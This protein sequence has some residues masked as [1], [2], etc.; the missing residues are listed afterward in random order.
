VRS[1]II[2]VDPPVWQDNATISFTV[3]DGRLIRRVIGQLFFTAT[4]ATNANATIARGG[5][6]A[7][8]KEIRVTTL[9]GEP[10]IRT[11][12]RM[13][14]HLLRFL[15][16]RYPQNQPLLG[17]ASANPIISQYFAIPFEAV[18]MNNPMDSALLTQMTG[19]VKVEIDTGTYN[20]VSTTAS[21]WT[22]APQVKLAQVAVEDPSFC[23]F[24]ITRMRYYEFPFTTT[25]EQVVKI[26]AGWCLR[27]LVGIFV[28]TSDGKET[29]GLTNYIQIYDNRGNLV[30]PTDDELF[31]N[32]AELN[33]GY[34]DQF[35]RALGTAIDTTD[36]TGVASGN[37][38]R[39]GQST[40]MNN[41]GV[42]NMSFA[43]D[44]FV[45]SYYD[46][47]GQTDLRLRLDI[48]AA[49]TLEL[50]TI[51]FQKIPAKTVVA[52][53]RQRRDVA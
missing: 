10:I 4:D 43:Q 31:W 35:N 2:R 48:T 33:G 40:K 29:A 7:L 16:G 45:N 1:K 18:G 13:L 24:G 9:D 23:P 46:T 37:Y 26:D 41:A 14:P 15:Y 3:P 42:F 50:Q 20:T 19:P 47:A 25:G 22:T 51:E 38:Q 5:A 52:L 27:G 32:D 49:C 8:M 17:D 6:F 44:A 12:G 36:A 34:A 11:T 28:K 21:A 30:D 53:G 39:W